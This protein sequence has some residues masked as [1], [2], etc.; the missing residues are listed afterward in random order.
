MSGLSSLAQKTDLVILKNGDH[1][2]GEIKRLDLDILQLKTSST[3]T[4]QIKWYQ[5]SNIYAPDKLVQVE[6][7]DKT[8]I[9]GKLDTVHLPNALRIVSDIGE[10]NVPIHQ[11][12]TIFQ[13]KKLFWSRFAGNLGA[14]VS[15]TKASEVLQ[16]NYNAYISYTDELYFSAIDLNSMKTSQPDKTTSKQDATVNVNRT[17][18]SSQFVT[19]FISIQQNT[20]LDMDKRTA[21][22]GGYGVDVLHTNIARLRFTLGAT[23]NQELTLV[24]QITTNNA[25]GIVSFDARI[26]KYTDPEVYLTANAVWYPSFTVADRDRVE[27][28]VKLRVELLNNLFFETQFYHTYDSKPTSSTAANSDWGVVASFQ[29]TFGL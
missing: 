21:L 17:T 1:I 9:F 25:E 13:V 10:F 28:S 20:E 7:I 15:Y 3:S 23:A 22:G 18:I 4:V 6:L 5:V 19:V 16:T 8:K 2:T 27:T 14:G 12:V 24:E 26:F 11:V 29:Y